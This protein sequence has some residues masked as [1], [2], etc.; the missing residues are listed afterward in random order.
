MNIKQQAWETYLKHRPN[1]TIEQDDF[2]AGWDSAIESAANLVE[3]YIDTIS[4]QRAQH[5]LREELL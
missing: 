4:Y 2:N 1:T 3:G 5:V